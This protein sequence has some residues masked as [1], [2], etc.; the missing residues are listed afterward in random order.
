MYEWKNLMILRGFDYDS[1]KTNLELAVLLPL[2]FPLS[3]QKVESVKWTLVIL[4]QFR[5]IILGSF[6]STSHKLLASI[7]S[8]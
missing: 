8:L 1:T 5:F 7:P 6:W 3:S 4:H 2:V